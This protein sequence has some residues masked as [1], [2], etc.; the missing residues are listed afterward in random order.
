MKEDTSERDDE[1]QKA[2]WFKMRAMQSDRIENF[3]KALREAGVDAA[4]IQD[5]ASCAY[6]SGFAE[7]SHERFLALVIDQSA[8]MALVCPALSAN[9]AAR[10]GLTKI[11]SWKD[12]EPPMELVKSIAANW[13]HVAVDDLM[14]ASHL[15][16][17][18][19]TFPGATWSPAGELIAAVKRK[20]DQSEIEK[21]RRAAE[22]A[23]R[24][25]AEVHPT[26]RAGQTEL[27]IAV[28]LKDAMAKLGGKPTFTIVAVGAMSAEPHH[29][30][31]A[32]VV[33]S[34]DVVLC[35]FGCEYEGYQSDITRC[36]VA[37]KASEHQKAIYRLVYQGHYAA[38][39]GA[40][41]GIARTAL[42]Q[43]ARTEIEN[44]GRGDFFTHRLGHG[45][46]QSVHEEPYLTPGDTRPVQPGDCFSIEPGIYL[47]G[48]FGIRLENIYTMTET[49]A[50]S[51][52]EAISPELV[53][54]AG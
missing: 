19:S 30:S 29:H 46:G 53:E 5:P 45:I 27:E 36:V 7:D 11:L 35:D 40:K 24:A 17:L 9:Q 38:A 51:L 21:M 20:K 14:K 15:L 8:Q 16:M 4:L 13:S 33:K 10:A 25:W 1:L 12:G 3:A 42:D 31:D 34:G 48:D 54:V 26:I 6:F 49:G 50:V 47:P 22:I 18:Q 32:T 23:D 44:G 52:N 43:L 41:A 39:T 2:R 28:K 37:G